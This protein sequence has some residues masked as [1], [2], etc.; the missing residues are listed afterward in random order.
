[1]AADPCLTP[2]GHRDQQWQEYA[3]ELL[4]QSFDQQTSNTEIKHSSIQTEGE[5]ELEQ[6][7]ALE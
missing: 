3:Q 6:P 7:P 2:H 1:V 4:S 5:L